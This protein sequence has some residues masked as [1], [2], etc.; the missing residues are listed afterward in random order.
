MSVLRPF[1]ATDLFTFNN[2]CALRLSTLYQS[3]FFAYQQ[4][5]RLDRNGVSYRV[6]LAAATLIQAQYGIGFYL[7]YLAR[8][9]DLCCVQA[10]PSGR[11]MGYGASCP[12]ATSFTRHAHTFLIFACVYHH[13]TRQS[14]AKRRARPQICT[15]TS[16]R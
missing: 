6:L 4:S 14:S 7:S 16:R 10:A 15:D 1:R 9:P 13:A 11:L 2:M 3:D 5:R 12:L 8:W